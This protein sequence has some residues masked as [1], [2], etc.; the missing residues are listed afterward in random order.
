VASLRLVNVK[1]QTKGNDFLID[2]TVLWIGL[3][4]NISQNK[5]VYAPTHTYKDCIWN[6]LADVI[7]SVFAFKV[8]GAFYLV[9]REN[10]KERVSYGSQLLIT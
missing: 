7:F 4:D 10:K 6:V 2:M 9:I 5:L 3:T 1:T 8:L